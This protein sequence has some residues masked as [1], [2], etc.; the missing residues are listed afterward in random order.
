MK[1]SWSGSSQW[2]VPSLH[3]QTKYQNNQ[4]SKTPPM[5]LQVASGR[6]RAQ[7]IMACCAVLAAIQAVQLQSHPNPR[8]HC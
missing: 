6:R 5:S 2:L 7:T 8:Y 4:R 3:N 1:L